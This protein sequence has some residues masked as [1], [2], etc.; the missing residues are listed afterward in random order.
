M[1]ERDWYIWA[2]GF[3]DGEGCVSVNRQKMIRTPKHKP[4]RTHFTYTLGLAVS[5]KT[6]APLKRLHELFGGHLFTYKSCGVW[7][8]RWQHWSKGAKDAL[9]LILPYLLVKREIAELGIRFQ[10]QMTS[11]NKEFGRRGYP[12]EVVSGREVFYMQA[13][14][15]NAKNRANHRLPKY[16]GPQT[17]QRAAELSAVN[18]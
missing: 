14:G 17:L 15:L 1:T 8:W 3:I 9:E 10:E 7:Y 16:E 5:Q 4:Q 11:W 13:R 2:A 12:L 18:S 6:E